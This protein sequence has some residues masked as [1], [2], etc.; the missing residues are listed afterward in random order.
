MN[1]GGSQ[2]FSLLFRWGYV[3]LLLIQGHVPGWIRFVRKDRVCV[4]SDDIVTCF[5]IWMY[6]YSLSRGDTVHTFLYG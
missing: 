1:T 2:G 4:H 6:F 5:L 3:Y